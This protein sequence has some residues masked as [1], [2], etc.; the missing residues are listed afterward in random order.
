MSSL[1]TPTLG[2]NSQCQFSVS[3]G[4]I[5]SQN[6][7][8]GPTIESMAITTLPR[9]GENGA[10]IDPLTAPG[11]TISDEHPGRGPFRRTLR[12]V[13]RGPAGDPA[14]PVP[15]CCWSWPSPPVF[16]FGTWERQVG[17]T[18]FILR[19]CKQAAKSWKAFFFGSSDA[20]NF[21]TVDKPPAALWVME[22]SARIF[23]LSSW[24]ILVPQALEGVAAVAVLY[25][26]VKRWSSAGAALIAATVMALTPV[27]ALMFRFNN[28][29]ALLVLLLC[30]AA[31]ATTVAVEKSSSRWLIFAFSLVGLGFITKMMQAFLVV[32]GMAAAYFLAAPV[33]FWRR[34]RQL[35]LGAVA[36]VVSAGW[37]V[38]A[39]VLTPAADRPYIGGSQDNN[40]LNLIFGYN[41]FGRITGN[42]S[43]SVVGGGARGTAGQWGPTGLTAPVRFGNGDPDIL[44]PTRRPD[45]AGRGPCDH[46]ETA[47]HQP[48][49]RCDGSM[50]RLANCH[51]TGFQ[52][53]ARNYSPLLHG[54]ARPC[55]RR[56]HRHRRTV[57]VGQTFPH[58]RPPG[59]GCDGRGERGM[60]RRPPRPGP[61]VAPVPP[62]RHPGHR[63]CG[64]STA[65]VRFV[66]RASTSG[67]GLTGVRARF[68][69]HRR[70]GRPERLHA[71]YR[72]DRP[73]GCDP[74]G[75]AC[76]RGA[77]GRVP[78]RRRH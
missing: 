36:M 40:L 5:R 49:P 11:P 37:W 9:S 7:G 44:A 74:D 31:Y 54:G 2:A 62:T 14:W 32:P 23:G 75:R 48:H 8:K 17:P 38:A 61:H 10:R 6:Q 57:P 24:S 27:A 64:R 15:P 4:A 25:A 16:T 77:G 12:R 69:R 33:T 22:I 50:G 53:G 66:P 76:I 59:H 19:P 46:V 34:V 13:A 47:A 1:R 41:G 42:E 35:A 70:A 39:V 20:S 56:H 18:A 45:P 21:I 28:P 52:P 55:H 26:A 72:G 51:R 68:G 73:L 65:R 58:V 78:R 71:V 67:A 29:D 63:L 60:G 43:G 30:G 3:A